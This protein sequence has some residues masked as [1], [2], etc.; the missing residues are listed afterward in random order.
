[1]KLG[2]RQ[3]FEDDLRIINSS[4]GLDPATAEHMAGLLALHNTTPE[5]AG[6]LEIEEVRLSYRKA[7]EDAVERI[8]GKNPDSGD[9]PSASRSWRAGATS[10]K[11][12]TLERREPGKSMEAVRLDVGGEFEQAGNKA[13]DIDTVRKYERKV[14]DE[15]ALIVDNIGAL[16]DFRTADVEELM[17]LI[18]ELH[19]ACAEA[20]VYMRRLCELPNSDDNIDPGLLGDSLFEILRVYNA[21]LAYAD[22]V[23]NQ[24]L[25]FQVQLVGDLNDELNLLR[26][27]YTVL[28]GEDVSRFFSYMKTRK[29]RV[30]QDV[31]DVMHYTEV[32][33]LLRRWERLLK[34][35][36][37]ESMSGVTVMQDLS[38]TTE[39]FEVF[40]RDYPDRLSR[41]VLRLWQR[42]TL[43]SR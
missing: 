15:A 1:M 31:F 26:K 3:S 35:V 14:L 30:A 5:K 38:R 25:S 33:G 16:P 12:L 43:G 24:K 20:A 36:T 23:F 40:A 6:P 11:K 22:H 29:A 32:Y 28:A 10:V 4:G 9:E 8:L 17:H 18:G 39:H 42:D 2:S 34:T 41:V 13:V 21:Y 19:K 7:V 27:S 37:P